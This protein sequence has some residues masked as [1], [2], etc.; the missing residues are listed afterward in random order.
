MTLKFLTYLWVF[1]CIFTDSVVF[2]C[3]LLMLL[4]VQLRYYKTPELQSPKYQILK[5]MADYEVYFL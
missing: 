1:A 5:R 3:A 2:L 4:F